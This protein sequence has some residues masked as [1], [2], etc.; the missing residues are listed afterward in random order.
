MNTPVHSALILNKKIQL[1]MY[2]LLSF[3]LH[4]KISKYYHNEDFKIDILLI[5]KQVSRLND[6]SQYFQDCNIRNTKGLRNI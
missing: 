1:S 6:R 2:I 5:N 3:R 4:F